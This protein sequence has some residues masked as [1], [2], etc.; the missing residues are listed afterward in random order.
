MKPQ[1]GLMIAV[2][3]LS[4]GCAAAGT[5]TR[6]VI[7]SAGPTRPEIAEQFG[8][9]TRERILGGSA[10]RRDPL[11]TPTNLP[12]PRQADPASMF[13]MPSASERAAAGIYGVTGAIVLTACSFANLD[14]D[15]ST[16]CDITPRRDVIAP[17]VKKPRINR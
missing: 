4:Q 1:F 10:G 16:D 2:A 17:L 9:G 7:T 15:L 12:I 6:G 14:N 5:L 8:A 13:R 11:H 3:I